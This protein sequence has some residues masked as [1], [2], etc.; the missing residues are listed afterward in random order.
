MQ[1]W[2]SFLGA[3]FANSLTGGLSTSVAVFCHELPHELGK[4][5]KMPW[6][7]PFASSIMVVDSQHLTTIRKNL[8]FYFTFRN[9]WAWHWA[10]RC[11]LFKLLHMCI[12]GDFAVLLRAGMSVRQALTYNIV[13]SVLCFLGMFIGIILGNINSASLWIFAFTAGTF[14]YIS[15]V[16]MVNIWIF[17]H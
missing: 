9:K 10:P 17:P 4:P 16:D 6:C 5:F 7:F 8:S 3:A 14:I 11:L 13:S 15:L 12:A 2:H 1:F